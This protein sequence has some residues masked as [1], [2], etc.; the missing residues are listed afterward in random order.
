MSSRDSSGVLCPHIDRAQLLP[1]CPI[2]VSLLL[3]LV[4]QAILIDLVFLNSLSL[5]EKLAIL[6]L[7]T[8]CLRRTISA[9]QILAAHQI[10]LAVRCLL[11]AC[12]GSWILFN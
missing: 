9:H 12:I 2:L 10:L 4:K 5:E 11:S 8:W 3:D 1:A 7:A 6:E